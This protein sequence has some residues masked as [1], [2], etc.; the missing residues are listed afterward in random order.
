MDNLSVGYNLRNLS[1]YISNMRLYLSAQDVFCLTAYK[2]VNP[3]VSLSGLQPG[4]EYMSYYP[5][6]TGVTIGVNITF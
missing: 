2:G 1:T 3:E 4:I 5:V 6:T